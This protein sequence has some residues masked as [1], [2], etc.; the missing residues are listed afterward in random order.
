MY[1]NHDEMNKHTSHTFLSFDYNPAVSYVFV[2]KC[3]AF[4]LIHKL[5]YLNSY[6]L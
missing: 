3:P 6:L 5:V 1:Q 4:A 2:P